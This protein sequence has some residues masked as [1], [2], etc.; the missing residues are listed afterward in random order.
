M[1]PHALEGWLGAGVGCF[2]FY[3]LFF[4]PT[5]HELRKIFLNDVEF[6]EKQFT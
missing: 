6:L 5:S 1:A 3:K 2:E 4:G